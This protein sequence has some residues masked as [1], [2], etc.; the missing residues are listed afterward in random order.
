VLQYI[1]TMD[2]ADQPTPDEWRHIQVVWEPVGSQEVADRAVTTFD[3]ANIT[4]GAIDSSWTDADYTTVNTQVNSLILAWAAHM[5]SSFRHI[6]TRYYRRLFNPLTN[7]KPFTQVGAPER[8]YAGSVVGSATGQCVRQ[9]AMTTTER[10]TYPRHWGRNYWP[11]PA[12]S[13][14]SPDGY[15]NNVIVD[16]FGLSVHDAYQTLQNAEFFPVVPVTYVNKVITRGLLTVTQLQVDN[17]PD[18]IR[19]RRP[20]H[21]THYYNAPITP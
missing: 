11:F 20:K 3:I 8:V 1:S 13:T 2:A 9:T 15:V 6:E 12:S 18:V 19:R 16:A 10:T 4:G 14:F 7:D 21:A 5:N 17:V